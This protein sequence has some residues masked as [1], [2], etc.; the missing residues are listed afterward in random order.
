MVKNGIDCIDSALPR[1]SGA[2]VGLITNQTGVNRELVSTIDILH[3]N[4]LLSC[5]FAP[6]HGIR[7]DGQAGAGVEDTVDSATGTLVYSL[8]GNSYHIP[9]NLLNELDVVAFDIQDVGARFYTYTSTLFRAMQDCASMGKQLVIFDRINPIGGACAEG[10]VLDR[11]FSSFVGMYP[12]ATRHGLT[13]GEYANYIYATENIGCD[14]TV[15]K[16]KGWNRDLFYDETD[17]AFIPPSPNM[18]TVDTCL[19]Y[20]GTCLAEGTNLSEGRGTT[21]PFELIGAPWLD[22]IRV[23]DAVNNMGLGGVIVRPCS[24]TPTFSKYASQGCRGVQLHV[25]D[26]YAFKP[27]ETAMRM[28]EYI[29]KT[30]SEFEFILPKN[31]SNPAFVDL[32]L[33]TDEWRTDDFDIDAFLYR[34]N[35]KISEYNEKTKEF[36]LY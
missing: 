29:R 25:T 6:E 26:R 28:F 31:P 8:Y 12:V 34:Q 19:A 21:K 24:F 22:N 18:P 13:V 9:E 36:Y 16:C 15:I 2:R 35:E 33:G 14:L 32:L 30:H 27:F 17:L 20:I 7:G 11:R 10:T 1:L 4:K 3:K 5:L 23:A